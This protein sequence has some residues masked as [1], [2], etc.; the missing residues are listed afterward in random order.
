M[1]RNIRNALYWL[2]GALLLALP[3]VAQLQVGDNLDMNLNGVVG[4]GYSDV[5]GNPISSSHSLD[6][7]GN[8]TLSGF[9]YNPNFVNFSL[10]PYYNKSSQNSESRSI[11]D[12]SGF[13]FNSGLFGGSHFPGSISYSR[14]WDSQGSFGIQIGRASCRERV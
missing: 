2:A 1:W 13:E 3:A 8:G 5:F 11:F 4:V 10:S 14:S 7:S 6:F 12:S 9:Y